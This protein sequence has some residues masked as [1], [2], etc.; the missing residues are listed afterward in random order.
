MVRELFK[1]LDTNES[2]RVA[3]E[4]FIGGLLR[5]RGQA[6]AR[7]ILTLR[8]SLL[9]L[10]ERLEAI[11]DGARRVNLALRGIYDDVDQWNELF[12]GNRS[13][14]QEVWDA[15]A[16]NAKVSSVKRQILS[17]LHNRIQ[18]DREAV[19]GRARVGSTRHAQN[20]QDGN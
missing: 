11:E 13:R 3:C 8:V 12:L 14:C 19:L 10:L 18:R 7:D 16:W 17:T 5:L 20:S 9:S 1:I 4:E 15:S 2:G 6:K